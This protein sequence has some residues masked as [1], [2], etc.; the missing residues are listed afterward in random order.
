M[1]TEHRVQFN[2]NQLK[3]L[4]EVFPMKP[5]EI[6]Q[7]ISTRLLIREGERR[8]INK[9]KERIPKEDL[10]WRQNQVIQTLK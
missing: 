8:V 3:F 1:N 5:L 6:N 2:I 4:E 7:D 10:S 9:I